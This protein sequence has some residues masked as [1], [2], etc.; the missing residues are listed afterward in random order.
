[1]S[2]TADY[3]ITGRW[4]A[5]T[6]RITNTSSFANGHILG[7]WRIAPRPNRYT[8]ASSCRCISS[9]DRCRGKTAQSQ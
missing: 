6:T 3:N 1:M 2:T 4:L 9:Q 5:N 7:F 8:I